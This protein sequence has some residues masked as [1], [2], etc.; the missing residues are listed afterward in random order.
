MFLKRIELQR[1]KISSFQSYPFS[2]PVMKHFH[3]LDLKSN[4]TF[5]SA[6]MAQENQH[7]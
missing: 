2:I 3:R 6:K 7:C 1:E 4:V 5:L